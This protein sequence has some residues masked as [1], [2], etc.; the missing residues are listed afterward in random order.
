MLVLPS[1]EPPY[2]RLRASREQR[3]A[4]VTLAFEGRPGLEPCDL[5]VSR[6]GPT[7]AVDTLRALRARY[8]EDE[9]IYLL[10]ADALATLHKWRGEQWPPR[11]GPNAAAPHGRSG[12]PARNRG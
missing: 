5:E 7:Y 6:P 1:G 11:H 4:M 9:L 3:M 2:K 8:P 10:G 12:A